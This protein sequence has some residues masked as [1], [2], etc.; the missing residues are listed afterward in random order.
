MF[1]RSVRQRESTDR[2]EF[3]ANRPLSIDG[4]PATRAAFYNAGAAR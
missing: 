4:V 2:A 3:D 1:A